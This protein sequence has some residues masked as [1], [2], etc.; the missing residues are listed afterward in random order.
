MAR[1]IRVLLDPGHDKAEYNRGAVSGY[2]EGA[3]MWALAQYLK[4]A[5]ERYGFIV[6][7][8]K[9]KCNQTVSVVARGRMAHAYDVFV[10]LH[11]NACDTPSVDRPVGIYMVDD[12]CGSLDDESRDLAVLLANTVARVMGTQQ[13][14]TYSKRSGKDRD[15]DGRKN[16]DYYGMLYGAHQVGVPGVIV[17]HSFHT[18]ARAARWL[19]DNDNLRRLAEAEAAALADYYGQ[20]LTGS[21]HTTEEGTKVKMQTVKKGSKHAHVKVLQRLLIGSGYSVG[22]SGVDGSFGPATDTALRKYQKAN[23]LT[24]DGSCGPATWAK[25]LAQ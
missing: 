13:A 21:V 4:P 23:G 18:N 6:G 1:A 20:T 22:S 3:Q 5:L 11:S 14:Q 15:G 16:D 12:G 2:W 17:E 25:L 9:K 10:S 19:L 8:T 24:V 7:L